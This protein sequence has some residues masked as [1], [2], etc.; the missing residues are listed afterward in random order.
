MMKLKWIVL[1]SIGLFVMQASA[2]ETVVIDTETIGEQPGAVVAETNVPSQVEAGAVSQA[3]ANRERILKGGKMSARQKHEMAKAE[4]SGSNKQQGEAFLAANKVKQGVVTLVSG[5]QY[6]V[7]RAGQGKMP[8]DT[9]VVVCRY[10][11]AL[12]D[13][14]EFDKSEAKKSVALNVATLLPGLKEAVKLMNAGSKWQIVIPPQ[15]A[16]GELGDRGVGQNAVLIYDME[17]ISI[18]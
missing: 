1:F 5:L 15:L 8:T 2:E 13:G 9:S 18:K 11:G 3:D 17:I 14:T 16:Y 10:R 7:L 6:K 12:I 4:I